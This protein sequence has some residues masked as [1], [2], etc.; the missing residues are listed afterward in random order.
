MNGKL[1]RQILD[2]FVKS[3]AAQDARVLVLLPELKNYDENVYK[4][5]G[6]AG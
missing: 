1:L 5:S 3:P 6:I 4:F 2:K